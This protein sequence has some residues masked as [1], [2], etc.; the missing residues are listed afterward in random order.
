[1]LLILML[2]WHRPRITLCDKVTHAAFAAGH[3][4]ERAQLLY[5]HDLWSPRPPPAA[6]LRLVRHFC[7]RQSVRLVRPAQL[8]RLHSLHNGAASHTRLLL[9][10]VGVVA[11]ASA[12]AAAV[13]GGSAAI[14]AYTAG[15]QSTP[16]DAGLHGSWSDR[17]RIRFELLV[18]SRGRACS[19]WPIALLLRPGFPRFVGSG[20][21]TCELV[22]EARV[23]LPEREHLASQ[24]CWRVGLLCRPRSQW[25]VV[26][27]DQVQKNSLVLP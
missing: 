26:G 15:S 5:G 16:D 17:F 4:Q 8:D 22:P 10:L 23:F 21:K 1:M 9:L 27:F 7:C 19:R 12:T 2:L 24:F 3:G 20:L 25:R 11:V 18:G 14:A 6:L 13:S